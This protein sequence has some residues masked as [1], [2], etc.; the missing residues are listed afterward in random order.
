MP[1][2]VPRALQFVAET[3]TP[4][5]PTLQDPA[6]RHAS[7]ELRKNSDLWHA[8]V[9]A[10]PGLGPSAGSLKLELCVIILE[11]GGATVLQ[12]KA[13]MVAATVEAQRKLTRTHGIPAGAAVRLA[14]GIMTTMADANTV[15]L[16]G[17]HHAMAA[18]SGAAEYAAAPRRAIQSF[19]LRVS[20]R[21]LVHLA[22]NDAVG[23]VWFR[24]T[25]ANA[26]VLMPGRVVL[27]DPAAP[28]PLGAV[29]AA[30]RAVLG[31]VGDL[32]AA[33]FLTH[34]NPYWSPVADLSLCTL[35]AAVLVLCILANADLITDGQAL[36]NLVTWVHTRQHWF[37]RAFAA[38]V[39]N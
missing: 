22:A 17:L 15:V 14:H 8:L 10:D 12:S 21:P 38:A 1:Y 31:P 35:G 32:D 16:R 23:T 27:V 34:A 19:V 29:V 25:H 26:L 4:P 18:I 7:E 11:G 33:A 6:I 13:D 36:T 20:L 37:L 3:D 2:R 9:D 28:A 30:L 24:S 5:P 39:H